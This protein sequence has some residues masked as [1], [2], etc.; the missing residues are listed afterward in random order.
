[1][2]AGHPGYGIT[3]IWIRPVC[4][5]NG[6]CGTGDL[7]VFEIV[8][9]RAQYELQ[10]KHSGGIMIQ[11]EVRQVSEYWDRIAPEFDTIYSGNKNPVARTLNKWLRRDMY[12][13][14]DWV[15]RKAGDVADKTVC[16]IG[17]GS[18]RFVSALAQR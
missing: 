16:D 7:Q 15:M 3:R 2:D 1:M 12:E 10:S 4:V 18:G 8:A 6:C 13:R 14:F 9:S 5:S 11:D 17:C